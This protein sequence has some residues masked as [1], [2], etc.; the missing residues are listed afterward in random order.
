MHVLTENARLMRM[1]E[2][3][4]GYDKEWF[5]GSLLTWGWSTT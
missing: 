5:R 3:V 1:L 4:G 2:L